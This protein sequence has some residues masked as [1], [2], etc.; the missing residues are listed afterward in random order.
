MSFVHLNVHDSHSLLAG[1]GTP[2]EY[3]A[4]AKRMGHPALAITN[5]GNLFNAYMFWKACK[6][7]GI[8]P[9]LGIDF[10]MAEKDKMEVRDSNRQYHLVVLAKNQE[11][12]NNL[13]RLSTMAYFEGRYYQP[14]IDTETLIRN[15]SGLIVI[16]GGPS[17]R[18]ATLS[19]NGDEAA[20][21]DDARRLR[22]AFKDDFYLEVMPHNTYYQT[23]L[24][25]FIY[26][27]SKMDDFK[28]VVTNGCRYPTQDKAQYYEYLY[29]IRTN[30]RVRDPQRFTSQIPMNMYYKSREELKAEFEAYGQF[31]VIVD[32]WLDR[33]LAIADKVEPIAFTDDFKL[34]VFKENEVDIE[35]PQGSALGIGDDADAPGIEEDE[36]ELILELDHDHE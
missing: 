25:K 33:A 32:S 2:E 10:F 29:L 30:K 19:S 9:I 12:W 16:G 23:E 14:R 4:L 31:P 15:G 22:D 13:V 26:Q 28:I 8:K 3:V 27:I 18:F 7:E 24:N 36:L 35:V 21:L 5:T 6:G 1:I 20:A 17:S 11:G 34:P